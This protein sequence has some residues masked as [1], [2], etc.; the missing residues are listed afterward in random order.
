MPSINAIALSK[1]LS[2][3]RTSNC[4][5]DDDRT[6]TAWANKTKLCFTFC[7]KC[8]CLLLHSIRFKRS[9]FF[10]FALMVCAVL[11]PGSAYAFWLLGFSTADTLPE[12]G[13]GAIAGTGGQYASVSGHNNF[14]PFLPHAGLRYGFADGWDVGYRLT[15]VALPFSGV[16]PSLGG[17]IDVKHRLTPVDSAWQA[18][19][20][21][22]GAY[23]FLELAGQSK[24][25]FSPG[26]DLVFSRAITPRF[27]AITELRYVYTAI[28]TAVGGTGANYL[29]AVGADFGLRIGL[30]KTVS[31]IP[32][33]GVFDF[34]GR[35]TN[36][37]A[38][39]VA[40]Q[41]GA[42]LAFRF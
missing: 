24:S 39:G 38:N 3:L 21:V 34:I 27:T 10:P 12:G 40:A 2:L 32:E 25:A 22:G 9:R 36:Q 11:V 7:Q 42:V 31:I 37:R 29:N 23:S 33:V 26:V 18:A 20:V 1:L 14:T 28:P 6:V 19:V 4:Y 17:E 35:L 5:R 15:Q 16:G 8:F 41:Y 30:T 13:F